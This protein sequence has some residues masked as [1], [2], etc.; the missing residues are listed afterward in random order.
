[1]ATLILD[2]IMEAECKFIFDR[3]GDN[4]YDEVWEGVTVVPPMP[5]D[6]HQQLQI[7]LSLPFMEL[8]E[9]PQI[10]QVRAGGN[11]SDRAVDWT[12]NYRCPD[13][14]VYLN[15][16]PA[17]NHDTHWQ[18][19]PDFLIEIISPGEDPYAKFAFYTSINTREVLIVHRDP[20]LLELFQ[21]NNNRLQLVGAS[22][23]ASSQVLTSNV[24]PLTFQLVQGA[25]R[26]EIVVAHTQTQQQWRA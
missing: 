22:D 19:G 14:F 5:S 2:P 9:I 8:V 25:T 7:R 24:L 12:H 3:S 26:P 21:L 15:S 4:R 18:G 6:E 11:I 13:V 16:N 20:W 23:T 10:G 1:M 17:I